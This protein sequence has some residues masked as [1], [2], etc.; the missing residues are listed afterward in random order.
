MSLSETPYL[1][2]LEAL[3]TL[4]AGDDHF[5][6]RPTFSLD[7]ISRHS[8]FVNSS[9]AV[10]YFSLEPW[11]QTMEKE[12]QGS[13]VGASFR[14]DV[15]KNGP[16]TL[17]E[18]LLLFKGDHLPDT[19]VATTS[20]VVIHEPDIGYFLLTASNDHPQA[21]TMDR[22]DMH[23]L[24]TASLNDAEPLYDEETDL[25]AIG[26]TRSAYQP[27]SSFWE[28]SA[29]STFLDKHVPSRYKKIMEDKVRLS[30]ATLDLMTEAHRILSQE[31]HQLGLA[32]A[33]LFR[34]CE[35]LQVEFREQIKRVKD[36]ATKIDH[37]LDQDTDDH[38]ALTPK[39][40][41]EALTE[42]LEQARQRQSRL[43]ARYD[44]ARRKSAKVARRALSE[45]EQAWA[46]EVRSLNS[47]LS[48]PDTETDNDDDV[49]E[50]DAENANQDTH[51][52]APHHYHRYRL[53]KSLLADILARVKEART[54][55]NADG[56]PRVPVGVRKA[57]IAQVMGLLERE[58]VVLP[59]PPSF[60][61]SPIFCSR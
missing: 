22:P 50:P 12:L 30:H 3:E 52:D 6:E 44:E 16:G 2:I 58:Y 9:R 49:E 31:T 19:D 23:Q 15:F 24:F 33:D 56:D 51:I 26:P 18:R 42:R 39:K 27:P 20:C 61:F 45:K 14:I 60:V 21:V 4:D 17:R 36:T 11:L 8:F 34:R 59:P 5:T 43:H 48:A 38:E 7:V 35:R 53:A 57:K 37:V 41:N 25:L 54:D 13:G 40:G 29:L 10:Y 32:A 1:V 46:A 55:P 28:E 47:S